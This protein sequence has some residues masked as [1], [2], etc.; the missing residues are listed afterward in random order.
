MK[1]RTVLLAILLGALPLA[2]PAAPFLSSASY[3]FSSA[4]PTEFVIS[5]D[6]GAE[7]TSAAAH[8]KQ[9]STMTITAY[10]TATTYKVTI[11]GAD[12]TQVGTGGTTT[13][14]AT[15]LKDAL[16]ASV[17]ANFTPI[18]WTS[19]GAVITGTSDAPGVPYT[20]TTSVTGG[21]G[22]FAAPVLVTRADEAFLL[23]DLAALVFGHHDAV[24]KAQNSTITGS[25]AT[26]GFDLGI[27][28][29]NLIVVPASPVQP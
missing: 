16:N 8:L 22:T 4:Q 2:A 10:D 26:L 5:I 7:V 12:V 1:A 28:T 15:A 21:T 17:N 18:T 19:S 23:Y 27:E 20:P 14:T 25:A 24:V 29:P 3:I 6:D 11:G 9:V 13:T